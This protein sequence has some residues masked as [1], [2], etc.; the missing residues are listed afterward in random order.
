MTGAVRTI[1]WQLDIQLL[2]QPPS[3]L[4]LQHSTPVISNNN[5]D[6]INL[7]NMV[8]SVIFLKMLEFLIDN[9]YFKSYRRDFHQTVVGGNG[10]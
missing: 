2:I 9:I 8:D 7:Q 6:V 1:V 4:T 10:V 5:T 3:L